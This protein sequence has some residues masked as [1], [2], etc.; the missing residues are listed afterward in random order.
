MVRMR[1]HRRTVPLSPRKQARK[2]LLRIT[3]AS[4]LTAADE[5]EAEKDLASIIA[6]SL[7]NNPDRS[8]TGMLY[9]DR[10]NRGVVQVLEGP[11]LMVR[12]LLE[13]VIYNDRRHEGCVVLDEASAVSRMFPD[14]GMALVRSA[15]G[16]NAEL[17]SLK[18]P[19]AQRQ[20]S[21]AKTSGGL[22]LAYAR[23]R[24]A[25]TEHMHLLRLQYRSRL[26]AEDVQTARDILAGVLE[27]SVKHNSQMGIGGVLC[28]NPKTF[29]I[30]QILEGPAFAVTSTY[31]KILEDPRHTDVM[32]TCEEVLLDKHASVFDACWGML[33]TE[34]HQDT[35][36]LMDLSSRV[37]RQWDSYFT[38]TS[39]IGVEQIKALPRIV[40]EHLIDEA[41]G[42]TNLRASRQGSFV[43]A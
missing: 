37:Q 25:D 40:V 18:Q 26:L 11:A 27:S 22:P 15:A 41:T 6:T 28:L 2:D 14:W 12:Q 23:P 1:F 13:E 31:R 17:N 4:T 21:F 35:V 29:G 39:E 9:Y 7:R 24:S 5:V 36:S 42:G 10:S 34:T 32:L 16:R 33:Q 30:V 43:V 38:S 8:I 19:H 20:V 3:Y